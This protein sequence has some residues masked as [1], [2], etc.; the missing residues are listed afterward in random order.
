[1]AA[2]LINLELGRFAK[3]SQAFE[4]ISFPRLVQYCERT[5][6]IL[7][8]DVKRAQ[9]LLVSDSLTDTS[10][11]VAKQKENKEG[12]DSHIDKETDNNKTLGQLLRLNH[13][14]GH[15]V[16]LEILVRLYPRLSPEVAMK[17]LSDTEDKQMYVFAFVG[18]ALVS[19]F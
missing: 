8:A 13:G 4:T 6:K 14:E 15:W 10:E 5:P 16:L 2:L 19:L 1:M 9:R 18:D 11:V 17:I 12:G 7:D 3:A